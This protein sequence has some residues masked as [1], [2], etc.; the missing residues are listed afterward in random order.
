MGKADGKERYFVFYEELPSCHF[1]MLLALVLKA[2][3]SS[4][5][6][7]LF[8]LTFHLF[9]NETTFTFLVIYQKSFIYSFNNT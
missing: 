5:V 4:F 8:P 9:Q 7:D 3:R 2:G 1:F 6:L